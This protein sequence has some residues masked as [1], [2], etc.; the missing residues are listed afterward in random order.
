M[1]SRASKSVRRNQTFTTFSMYCR[2]SGGMISS[3][4]PSV[5]IWETSTSLAS[6]VSLRE[7]SMG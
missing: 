7:K 2:A 5:G 4:A 3:I 6:K 1:R